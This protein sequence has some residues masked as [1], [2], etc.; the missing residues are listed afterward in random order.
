MLIYINVRALEAEAA[1]E[2][3]KMRDAW[4]LLEMAIFPIRRGWVYPIPSHAIRAEINL[5]PTMNTTNVISN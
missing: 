4:D 3:T 2:T 1:A 5:V